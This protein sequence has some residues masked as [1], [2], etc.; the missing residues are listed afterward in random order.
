M[1]TIIFLL[2]LSLVLPSNVF[3]VDFLTKGTPAPYDGYLFNP[4]EERQI[5]LINEEYKYNKELNLALQTQ[6]AAYKEH[7]DIQEQRIQNLQN[8][9]KKLAD[10][11]IDAQ[12]SSLLHNVV[13]FGGGVVTAIMAAYIASQ[14]LKR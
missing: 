8:S 7:W 2:L 13:L 3:A 12:D 10:T 4:T 9:N 5:R 11:A 1:K 6:N 14:A